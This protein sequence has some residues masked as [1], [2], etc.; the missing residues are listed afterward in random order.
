M[1]ISNYLRR[2]P[3][4]AMEHRRLIGSGKQKKYYVTPKESNTNTLIRWS[5]SCMLLIKL[6]YFFPG[7]EA[8]NN[9]KQIRI[10]TLPC[11]IPQK[12]TRCSTNT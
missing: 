1:E 9:E 5:V 12:A 2:G 3:D 7:P 8:E 10:K 6:P 4:I 11:A